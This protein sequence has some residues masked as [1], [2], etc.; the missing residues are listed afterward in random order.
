MYI[1]NIDSIYPT[2]THRQFPKYLNSWSVTPPKIDDHFKITFFTG[3]V[4]WGD[5]F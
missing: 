1:Q 5:F 2:Q 4:T 3:E